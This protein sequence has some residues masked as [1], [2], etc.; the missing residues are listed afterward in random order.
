[1]D[2][3]RAKLLSGPRLTGVKHRRLVRRVAA[4]AGQIGNV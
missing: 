2:D 1:M 4:S 3:R